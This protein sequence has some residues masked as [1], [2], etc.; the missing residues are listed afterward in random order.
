VGGPGAQL[1]KRKNTLV[2]SLRKRRLTSPQLGAS[3]NSIRKTPV[4]TSTVK[5][6][7]SLL[8]RVAKKKTFQTGQL[9]EKIKDGQ[10]TDTGQKKIGKKC[11]GKTNLS[12]R[13]SDHKEH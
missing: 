9:K 2:S 13:C 8:G 7:A 11:Y 12:L 4:S 3:L 1:C 10:N 6:D 5:R